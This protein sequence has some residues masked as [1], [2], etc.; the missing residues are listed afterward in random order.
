MTEISSLIG[1]GILALAL[2][3][4]AKRANYFAMEE[5]P[6]K[7]T[8][9]WFDLAIIFL[10][11]LATMFLGVPLLHLILKSMSKIAEFSWLNFLSPIIVLSLIFIYSVF[12]PTGTLR[13]I[14]N[15]NGEACSFKILKFA[16]LSFIIAFPF[17]IFF[18]DILDLLLRHV[19]N[20]QELPEQLAVRFLKM[21]FQYPDLLVLSIVTILV[22][23]PIF[24][25]LLFRGFLQSF[26]R[27]YFGVKWAICIT[28]ICFALF[29]YSP[30]QGLAN[31]S[32]IGSLFVLA[33]FL[34]FA[35]EKQGTLATSMTLHAL[36]NACSVL[37][38]YF[39]R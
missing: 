15:R 3:Y 13:K 24:E 2:L 32:I 9:R 8:L 21:T 28:S 31:I 4:F 39:L 30:D 25:E 5:V 20:I 35:Y 29:H 11:Y 36:F 1:F 37:N 27:Q 34:G 38:L 23:A 16:A 14:W 17:V 12:L 6:W 10:L 18:N 22:L 7:V 33:L 19:F 26:L